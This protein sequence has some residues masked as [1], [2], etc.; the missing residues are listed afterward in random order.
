MEQ[1]LNLK[2][3]SKYM[4]IR[5][6]KNML[7]DLM[8]EY[9]KDKQERTLIGLAISEAIANIIEHAYFGDERSVINF[10]IKKDNKNLKFILTDYGVKK[11]LNKI[12]SRK[13]DEFREGGLGVHIISE[14]MD[15]VK[16]KHL[17]DGTKLIMI[18]RYKEGNN[19][20]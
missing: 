19:G 10:K 2:I 13:L 1:V 15:V 7:S 20:E 17:K 16:Y 4:Y 9:F 12:A 3:L 18:K 5:L 6:I 14:V 11:D 8:I